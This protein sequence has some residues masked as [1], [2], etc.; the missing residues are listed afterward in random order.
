MSEAR[1]ERQQSCERCGQ[2]PCRPA[3]IDLPSWLADMLGHEAKFA[4]AERWMS[5]A[6][7]GM[8]LLERMVLLALVVAIAVATFV[9]A[10]L[11]GTTVLTATGLSS[12][13]SAVTLATGLAYRLGRGSRNE[14]PPSRPDTH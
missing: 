12:S 3:N 11:S 6:E 1:G 5:L 13:A 2:A 7:R 8:G 4:N 10:L 14:E 9:G